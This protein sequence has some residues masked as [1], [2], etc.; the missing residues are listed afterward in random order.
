[1]YIYDTLYVYILYIYDIYIYTHI[2]MYTRNIPMYECVM[3]VCIRKLPFHF[4]VAPLQ[5]GRSKGQGQ[6]GAT[7]GVST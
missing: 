4:S 7:N 5:G 3:C 1:M 6:G 2:F